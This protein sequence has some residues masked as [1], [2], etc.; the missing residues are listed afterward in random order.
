MAKKFDWQPAKSQIISKF[1]KRP[2]PKNY[3]RVKDN[4]FARLK[5]I[6][7]ALS[8]YNQQLVKNPSEYKL[9]YIRKG[10]DTQIK[11]LKTLKNDIRIDGVTD[12]E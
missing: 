4:I 3:Q 5:G 7:L 12:Y 1:F 2:Y 8:S 11:H 9:N 6:D 10:I